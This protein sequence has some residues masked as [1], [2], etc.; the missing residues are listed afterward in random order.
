[1]EHEPH[2]ETNCTWNSA[3]TWLPADD[4]QYALDPNGKWYDEVVG[5]DIMAQDDDT[6]FAE[7]LIPSLKKKKFLEQKIG[8]IY[9]FRWWY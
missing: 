8:K 6:R 5:C 7:D 3:P 4:P 9:P 1:M 2:H